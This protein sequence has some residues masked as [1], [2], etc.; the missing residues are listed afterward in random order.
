[1]AVQVVRI[2][3][4]CRASGRRRRRLGR[5]PVSGVVSE[6]RQIAVGISHHRVSTRGVERENRR[7]SP[8]VDRRRRS[9]ERVV[10]ICRRESLLENP[11][12]GFSSC[13]PKRAW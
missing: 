1:M 9:I 6:R 11:T 5:Q 4:R 8:R 2:R 12:R 7:V 10:L 13:S 3:R